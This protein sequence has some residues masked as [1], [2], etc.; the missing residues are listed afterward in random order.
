MIEQRLVYRC[1]TNTLIDLAP[2][3]TRKDPDQIA[4]NVLT[5]DIPNEQTVLVDGCCHEWKTIWGHQNH[6]ECFWHAACKI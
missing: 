1:T 5:I 2:E 4:M 3:M 6:Y